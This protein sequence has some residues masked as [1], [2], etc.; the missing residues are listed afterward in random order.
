MKTNVEEVRARL[1]ERMTTEAEVAHEKVRLARD[2][3]A[4]R[5]ELAARRTSEAESRRDKA[6]AQ[7]TAVM[8]R[9]QGAAQET[10]RRGL[11]N[12][13]DIIEPRTG[14][15]N[16]LFLGLPAPVPE[17]DAEEQAAAKI[18]AVH[19]GKV[20]RKSVAKKREEQALAEGEANT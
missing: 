1:Q 2:R 8:A 11:D 15:Q 20:A 18:Q 6:L 13:A 19:R 5:S 17:N 16:A 10:R 3:Q 14:T 7:Y 4:Q 12:I 9:I